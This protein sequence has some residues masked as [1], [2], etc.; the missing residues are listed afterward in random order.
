MNNTLFK[1]LHLLAQLLRLLLKYASVLIQ[2]YK[3]SFKSQKCLNTIKSSMETELSN[4]VILKTGQ[5][6]IIYNVHGSMPSKSL[7]K[8]YTSIRK[9]GRKLNQILASPEY[10]FSIYL[11]YG[12]II[13]FL[14]LASSPKKQ[15]VSGWQAGYYFQLRYF[16]SKSMKNTFQ[17]NLTKVIS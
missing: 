6:N 13:F 4:K 8:G 14:K 3:K 7:Q 1:L 2:F 5:F 15:P 9:Q 10:N 11:L 12:Y 17:M 16:D